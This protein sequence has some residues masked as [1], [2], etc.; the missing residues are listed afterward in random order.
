MSDNTD[1]TQLDDFESPEEE[2]IEITV[3]GK[4]ATFIIRD[5]S[6]AAMNQ[7]V[8]PLNS[9]DAAK[10]AQ[11]QKDA[12]AKIISACIKRADGRAITFEEASNFRTALAKQL[13]KAA[14]EFNGLLDDEKAKNE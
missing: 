1:K 14:M 9:Q 3:R 11:A 2:A 13:E 10:K 5:I 7:M 4:K 12:Q 8:A 6:S